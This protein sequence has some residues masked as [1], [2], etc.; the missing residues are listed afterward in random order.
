MDNEIASAILE[1][2]Q[3]INKKLAELRTG[4]KAMFGEVE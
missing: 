4:I 2:L 1:E 3:A